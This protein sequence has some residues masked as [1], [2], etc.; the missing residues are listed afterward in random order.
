MVPSFSFKVS[1]YKRSRDSSP[2]RILYVTIKVYHGCDMT[3]TSSSLVKKI[4]VFTSFF[5]LQS[6]ISSL[7]RCFHSCVHN[8]GITKWQH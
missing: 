1:Y 8:E 7:N 4:T 6:G 2:G 3:E 5:S